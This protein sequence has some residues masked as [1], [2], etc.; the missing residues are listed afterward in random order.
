MKW[1][2]ITEAE[3]LSALDG[4]DRVEKSIHERINA[5]KL[6]GERLL[7]VTYTDQG[8]DLMVITVIEKEYAGGP[9]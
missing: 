4:P 8:G 7:K 2:R 5:Y 9:R 1:R 3:A 6:V